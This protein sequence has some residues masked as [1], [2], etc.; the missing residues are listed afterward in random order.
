MTSLIDQ[1]GWDGVN[2]DFEAGYASDR[3]AMT[4]FM[5]DLSDRVHARGKLLSQAVSAKTEDVANH[6]RSTIFDYAELQKYVDYVFVMAWGVHWATSSPGPQDDY[7]WVR[8][9]GDY[10]ASMPNKHKFVMGTMLYAFDWP[11][12]GGS[13]NPAT[14]LHYGEVVDL[15]AAHRR[16]AGVRRD[17][18]L[19]ACALPRRPGPARTMSGTATARPSATAS[20]SLAPAA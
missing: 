19:V 12:G 8:R 5:A 13:G 1:Y 6:P 3:A 7:D 9:V 4:A 18:P 14:A 16:H 2:I 11:N 20:S 15:I 10:V 17:P